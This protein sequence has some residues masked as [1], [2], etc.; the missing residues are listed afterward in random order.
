MNERIFDDF[1]IPSLGEC[2]IPSP[3]NFSRFTPES[4]RLLFNIYLDQYDEQRYP[5]GLPLSLDVAGPR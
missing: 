4:K 1:I 2:S 3:I 5:Q